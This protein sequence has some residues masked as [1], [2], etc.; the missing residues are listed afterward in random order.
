I[1]IIIIIIIITIVIII[2]IMRMLVMKSI[3]TVHI[4]GYKLYQLPMAGFPFAV[5]VQDTVKKDGNG[6]NDSNTNNCN[7]SDND[8]DNNNDG[9]DNNKEDDTEKAPF[10]V[11]RLLNWNDSI[12]NALK[13]LQV[14]HIC[15]VNR[16]TPFFK[17][18]REIAVSA[19]NKK[20]RFNIW[21]CY[22]DAKPQIPYL[23][24]LFYL[25]LFNKF[26][27]K[28]DF[29]FCFSKVIFHILLNCRT[30]LRKRKTNLYFGFAST[31][32]QFFHCNF[33]CFSSFNI[34]RD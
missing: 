16:T 31:F 21:L 11:G 30:V 3:C 5:P 34:T 8:N 33:V 15:G 7:D 10:I 25:P 32:F 20:K 17:R 29:P 19:T 1:I 23:L 28:E 6:N 13:I 18:K 27:E 9:N 14:D 24:I 12:I 4:Y 26:F 22:I 2:M